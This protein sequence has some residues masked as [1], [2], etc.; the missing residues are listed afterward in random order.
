MTF[1]T[2]TANV[3]SSHRTKADTRASPISSVH[4]FSLFVIL[5]TSVVIMTMGFLKPG[6]G[7]RFI[8]RG[9][10]FLNKRTVKNEKSYSS[11]NPQRT[12]VD[13]IQPWVKIP[14][15]PVCVLLRFSD[16]ASKRF[17]HWNGIRVVYILE[18][19]KQSEKTSIGDKRKYIVC[20]GDLGEIWGGYRGN[21][22]SYLGS[23]DMSLIHMIVC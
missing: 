13:M 12:N 22:A 8:L 7:W 5:W 17:F 23:V 15:I 21:R 19:I 11:K 3:R 9:T 20:C 18:T 2:Q 1:P 14:Q 10:F 4:V 16:L 6:I